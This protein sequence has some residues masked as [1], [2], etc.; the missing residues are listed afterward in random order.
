LAEL[1]SPFS[2]EK[3]IA[4]SVFHEILKKNRIPAFRKE[5]FKGIKEARILIECL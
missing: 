3:V 1:N 4:R 5:D 2:N